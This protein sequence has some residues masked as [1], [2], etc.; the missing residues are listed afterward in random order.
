MIYNKIV[1]PETGRLVNIRGRL[2][3]RVLR[4]YLTIL[5]GGGSVCTRYHSN[6][7]K[8]QSSRDESGEYCVYTA[9]RVKGE[10]GQC[11]K[12]TAKDKEEAKER[13][14]RR[15]TLEEKFQTSAAKM[16]QRRYRSKKRMDK[17]IDTAEHVLKK[18]RVKKEVA[19]RKAE[20]AANKPKPI[21]CSQLRK[22]KC[23]ESKKCMLTKGK[24]KKCV[25]CDTKKYSSKDMC[26]Y[27]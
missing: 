22:G 12:S 17:F 1:N 23:R 6:P 3:R 7:I 16:V 10:I 20:I 24:R 4:N 11:R 5:N 26:I 2:G 19:R 14:R 18:D 15:R 9:G 21:K 13:A 27:K 25:P 8:C